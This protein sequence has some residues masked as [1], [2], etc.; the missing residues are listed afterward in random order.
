MKMKF[1]RFLAL[2][3]AILMT[4]TNSGFSLAEGSRVIT[5]QVSPEKEQ[6]IVVDDAEAV[7]VHDVEALLLDILQLGA[8]DVGGIGRHERDR[9]Y[10]HGPK[11]ALH[12]ARGRDGRA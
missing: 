2:T 9:A 7:L 12:R 1:K 5:Q 4:L 11:R 10:A 3:M 6:T 8:V